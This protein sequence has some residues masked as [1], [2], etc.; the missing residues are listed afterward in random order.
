MLAI[1]LTFLCILGIRGSRF[2]LFEDFDVS[3]KALNFTTD[4]TNLYNKMN[5]L[6]KEVKQP[7]MSFYIDK[8]LFKRHLQQRGVDIPLV[9]FMDHFLDIPWKPPHNFSRL[10]VRSG[11]KGNT[12]VIVLYMHNI[13]FLAGFPQLS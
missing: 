2:T 4:D 1:L 11:E 13:L 8:V 9:Y 7:S 3:E 6:R 5:N 12:S 10:Q